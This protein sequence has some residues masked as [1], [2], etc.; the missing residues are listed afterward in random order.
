ML[1][2]KTRWITYLGCERILCNCDEQLKF[3]REREA[4]GQAACIW[5]TETHLSQ[6]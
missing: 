3:L 4:I 5:Q 2:E 6:Y 1:A